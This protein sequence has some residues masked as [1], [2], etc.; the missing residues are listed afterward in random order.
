MGT[1]WWASNVHSIQIGCDHNERAYFWCTSKVAEFNSRWSKFKQDC[2]TIHDSHWVMPTMHWVVPRVISLLM[3]VAHH[4]GIFYRRQLK[5]QQL[6]KSFC[7]AIAINPQCKSNKH[8]SHQ[9][10]RTS[11]NYDNH[12]T[13]PWYNFATGE[14]DITCTD[15][16]YTCIALYI[17]HSFW[18]T[19]LRM[20]KVPWQQK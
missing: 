16:I 8:L 11:T 18:E 20:M 7:T 6:R 2:I 14:C 12:Q 13:W 5:I 3:K 15:C 17:S 10:T 19:H 9:S 1:E 4:S